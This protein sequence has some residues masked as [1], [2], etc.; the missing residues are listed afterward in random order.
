MP[1]SSLDLPTELQLSV[2]RRC[3]LRD[4]FGSISLVSKRL[5]SLAEDIFHNEI[6]PTL[7]IDLNVWDEGNHQEHLPSKNVQLQYQFSVLEDVDPDVIGCSLQA[8]E[9]EARRERVLRQMRQ[10]NVTRHAMQ[11]SL[12]HSYVVAMKDNS[13]CEPPIWRASPKHAGIGDVLLL[14]WRQLLAKYL[15]ATRVLE[16]MAVSWSVGKSTFPLYWN[17]KSIGQS[18]CSQATLGSLFLSRLPC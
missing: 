1:S 9:P 11:M 7:R 12:S 4:L 6:L 3:T 2:L 16:D 8:V 17:N 15:K 5:E 10:P 18:R 13:W 14:E